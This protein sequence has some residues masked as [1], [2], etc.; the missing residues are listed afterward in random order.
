[1]VTADN[2][3]EPERRGTIFRLPAAD[4]GAVGVPAPLAR[5]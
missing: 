3:E 2:T 1:V 4:I 5:V